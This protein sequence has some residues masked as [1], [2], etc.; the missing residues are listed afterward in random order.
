M[1]RCP[2]SV[3]APAPLPLKRPYMKTSPKRLRI[4]LIGFALLIALANAP[5]F[6]GHVSEALLFSPTKFL[7]GEWW[8]LLTGPLTHVSLYHLAL[9]AGAFLLL[10]RGL[11][12]NTTAERLLLVVACALGSQLFAWS[13]LGE[14][15]LCGLSGV[16]HGLMAVSALDIARTRNRTQRCVGCLTLA[17]VTGKGL[18]EAVSGHVLFESLHLGDVATPVAICHLGGIVGGLVAAAL[19]VAAETIREK[20][21]HGGS[22]WTIASESA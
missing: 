12:R 6:G 3:P 10:Y 1:G 7:A 8:L 22:R 13:K 21:D 18:F 2:A 17:A 14:G 5:L 20:P 11:E 15:T 19:L 16:A 9:D 4:E